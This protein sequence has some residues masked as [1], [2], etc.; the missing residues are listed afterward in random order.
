MYEIGDKFFSFL[1]KTMLDDGKDLFE[2][3]T[4]WSF[5]PF[6]TETRGPYFWCW[7]KIIGMDIAYFRDICYELT[8]EREN[9]MFLISSENT[10][11]Y[12][13]LHRD[14]HYRWS[15]SDVVEKMHQNRRRNIVGDIA[16]HDIVTRQRDGVL[17]TTGSMRDIDLEN[18]RVVDMDILMGKSF[19]QKSDHIR[20]YLDHRE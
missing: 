8:G 6:E 20:I 3:P 17:L 7:H 18:I 10:L 4:I 9:R 14:I 13:L 16:I 19:F 5:S 11:C 12:L 2:L 1:G 15:V